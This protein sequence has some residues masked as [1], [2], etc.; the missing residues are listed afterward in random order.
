MHS[1]NPTARFWAAFY[2][3]VALTCAGQGREIDEHLATLRAIADDV[4]LP[5]LRWESTTQHAW[6]RS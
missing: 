2:R 1:A 5:L 6:P 3:V 4:G